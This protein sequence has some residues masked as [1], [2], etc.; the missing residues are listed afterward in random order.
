MDI[1]PSGPLNEYFPFKEDEE[2][3][4]MLFNSDEAFDSITEIEDSQLA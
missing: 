3:T 4:Y 1:S 2:A